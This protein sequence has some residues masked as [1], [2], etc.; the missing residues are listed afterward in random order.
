MNIN[1]SI[2][3]NQNGQMV[4]PIF[5]EPIFN[6]GWIPVALRQ[7]CLLKALGDNIINIHFALNI[8]GRAQIVCF[9]SR[10][11]IQLAFF[12]ILMIKVAGNN[13][14]TI[15]FSR[16]CMQIIPLFI[17]FLRR[18]VI[19]VNIKNIARAFFI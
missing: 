6:T 4:R 1:Q 19:E 15:F 13:N 7:G 18:L 16:N 8:I 9:K 17:S 14:T 2:N 10:C 12:F 5:F 3:L 11:I